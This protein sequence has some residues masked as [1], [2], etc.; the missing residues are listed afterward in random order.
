MSSLNT[1]FNVSPYYDDYNEDKKFSKVLFKPAVALQ[2]R[3]L[4]QLQTILQAQV[5]RFGNNVYKEG[6]IIEGCQISLDSDYDFVKI[7]D[8]QT[9]GQPVAP[10]TYKGL[11]A[12]GATS[13]VVAVVQEYADGL[14]SQ[15]PNLTT[16]YIDYITTGI[17]GAKTFTTTENIQIYSDAALSSLLTTVTV[18]GA[19]VSDASTCIGQG[20]AVQTSEGVIYSK[21]HFLKVDEGIVIASKY[22][23]K[24]DNVSVGFDV[25]ES[26]VNSEADSSLLD[27]AS[28]YNNENAPGADR[29]KLE[30]FLTAIPTQDA[31][32]NSKFLAVMDFQFGLPVAKRLTTQFNVISDEMAQR[33]L[34]ESGNYTIRKNKIQAEPANTT[35]FNLL[36]GPGLHYVNGYRSEQ[37]NTSRLSIQKATASANVA[38]QTITTNLGNYLIVNELTG[39]FSSNTIPTVSLRDTAG[40]SLTDDDA[41]SSA[42]G[43][44][45]GTAKVRAFEHH[46]GKHGTAAC[47]FKLY[48]FD[49]QM[50]AGKPFRNV[51]ACHISNV[52]TADVVL[53]N[54]RA[55]LEENR[56]GG[57]IF[58]LPQIACKSTSSSDFIFR[59]EKQATTSSNTLTVTTVTGVFPY[60]GTLTNDQKKD[61]IIRPTTAAGGINKNVALD[62]DKCTISVSTGTA[63]IVMTSALQSGIS[64]SKTFNVTFNE[65]KTNVTPIKKTKKTLFVKIDCA[66]N[67]GG[68]VGPYSLGIPD[69]VEIK[70]VYVGNGTYADTNTES[71]SGFNLEKNCF[72]THYGLSA[73]SKKSTQTL[74]T[75]D[76][77]L[78]ELDAMVSAGPASG[79]GFY[80][81]SSFYQS[82]GTDL[83]APED[84]PVYQSPSGGVAD[85]RN[86]VDCRPQVANTANA[87]AT[88][89]GGATINPANT[90]AFASQ[91]HFLAAPNRQFNTDIDYYLGRIDK[92]GINEQGY[93][94]TKRGA[95]SSKP[96]PP[97]D[98]PN[99]LN[100]GTVII[101]P[102]PS[103]TSKEAR[104]K[105]RTNESVVVQQKNTQR[106]TMKEIAKIDKRLRNIEYYTTLS[107]LEQKT[108]NMAITDANGND[109]FK[110]GIFVDPATDFNS[111]DVRS[112]DFAIGIDPTA[113]EFIPKFKQEMIDL[114][115]ANN[116]NTVEIGGVHTLQA[117]EENFLSQTIATS[118]RPCTQVFYKFTGN[119]KIDP[120]Y[121]SGYDESVVGT[122]D[123]FVDSA[124]GMQDLLD[125]INEIYPLTK[126]NI[127]HIGTSTDVQSET[128]VTTDTQTKHYGYW[129]WDGWYGY[130]YYGGHRGYYGSHYGYGYYDYYGGWYGGSYDITTETA[131]T[132]TTT[133]TT[134]TYLKTTQQLAMGYEES[135]SSV[136]D[137]VTDISFSPFMRSKLIRIIATG[138]RPNTQHYVFFDNTAVAAHV[139]PGAADQQ[140]TSS[141]TLLDDPKNVSRSGAFNDSVSSDEY[142]VLLAVFR[143]PAET[144][145]VG[146]RQMVIADV[147]AIAQL[148]NSTSQGTVTYNA[149]NYSVEKET[150]TLTTRTPTVDYNVSEDTYTE[151][152]VDVDTS[153]TITNTY[154][155]NYYWDDLYFDYIHTDSTGDAQDVS[156]NQF[157]PYSTNN[158]VIIVKGTDANTTTGTGSKANTAITGGGGAIAREG[159]VKDDPLFWQR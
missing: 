23:D 90:E 141:T 101:P 150:L 19:Q 79:A 25:T 51:R 122:K 104:A 73:M 111:A 56:N 99:S 46:N 42:P 57:S 121:D 69:V 93:L 3:E 120:V 128:D 88:A 131:T 130:D 110:N 35:H 95:P 159:R 154:A 50:T 66:S 72:D 18:A 2:A 45:I 143:I 44:E 139:A 126:T 11:Y 133:T 138:L 40:T 107:Q 60:S 64:T 119:I 81:V 16:L 48:L 92:I 6:T 83:L 132:T 71:K 96:V 30:P 152:T 13:N 155:Y 137:F 148:D 21:G 28:G 41:L 32:A 117:R 1:N 125:G 106:Y 47:R 8:L 146:D 135:T 84:I 156:N 38:D 31:I 26:I 29:L 115:V 36:V 109:R 151:Q 86:M 34:D 153:T 98:I 97:Q 58:G 17:S 100:L 55:V 27:N 15:D 112:R 140:T 49:V 113:T 54:S 4:T 78:V 5:E 22:H 7:A 147:S 129:G 87:A 62:T 75:N 123:I 82:N 127:E 65:K 85:L 59:T 77:I 63:T 43:A 105:E 14:V 20:Y 12:K 144:F 134:D 52:G 67:P 68:I 145:L 124:T 158:E 149:Y 136:G 9:D 70:N 74:T 61:F 142:G 33:T 76:H 39:G 102:F 80:T 116:T 108:Q 53:K 24:P 37:Y 157:Y 94:T 10:S 118:H 103:L 91:D 89:A 114:K